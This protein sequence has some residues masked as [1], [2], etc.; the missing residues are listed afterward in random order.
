MNIVPLQ[1][2]PL[3]VANGRRVRGSLVWR[4]SSVQVYRL[5]LEGHGCV[6][7]AAVG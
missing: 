7:V 4:R 5:L 2:A 3:K 1:E 6:S